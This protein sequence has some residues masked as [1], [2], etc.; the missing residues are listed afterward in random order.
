M[1]RI[2]KTR[3]R[4]RAFQANALP[5]ELHGLPHFFLT[6]QETFS[7]REL[8]GGGDGGVGSAVAMTRGKRTVKI[9]SK[10]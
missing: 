8:F 3:L 6:L 4:D 9:T 1:H 2:L 5:R 10:M 7:S